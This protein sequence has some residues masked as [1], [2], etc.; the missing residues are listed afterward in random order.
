MK[1]IPRSEESKPHIQI[2]YATAVEFQ[3]LQPGSTFPRS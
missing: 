1:E 3:D 2:E